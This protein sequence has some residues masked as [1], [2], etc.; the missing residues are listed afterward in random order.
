M[1]GVGPS[2]EELLA[3]MKSWRHVRDVHKRAATGTHARDSAS[4]RLAELDATFERRLRAWVVDERQRQAWRNALHH[5]APTPLVPGPSPEV[6]F[7]GRSNAGSQV[8]VNAAGANQAEVWVD[9]S[10]VRR[11]PGVSLGREQGGPA[12]FRLD[13]RLEFE[14]TF[15]APR[16][17]LDALRAWSAH[18]GGEP[19]FRFVREL[20]DDGLVDANFSLTARGRRA[21]A[22]R[23]P[24]PA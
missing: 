9:G 11:Q 2:R 7:R 13:E 1:P 4:K 16:E 22:A 14:E 17:A 3:I 12:R 10:M 23:V 24:V 15:D 6:L 18:P 5:D 8:Q 20:I 19:P 21:V